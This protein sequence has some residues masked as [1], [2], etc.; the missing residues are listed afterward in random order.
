M[1]HQLHSPPKKVCIE[2]CLGGI[3]SLVSVFCAIQG[4]FQQEGNFCMNCYAHVRH[5]MENL[6]DLGHGQ[7]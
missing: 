3:S 5:L 2:A 1:M 7:S 4:F 6:T